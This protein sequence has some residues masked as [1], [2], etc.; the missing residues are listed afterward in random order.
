M[1]NQ[2][3]IPTLVS[4][5]SSPTSMERKKQDIIAY[6]EILKKQINIDAE[7]RFAFFYQHGIG[8][9]N[10][11][12]KEIDPIRYDLIDEIERIQENYRNSD[13]SGGPAEICLYVSRDS[14]SSILS[15]AN[16]MVRHAFGVLFVFDLGKDDELVFHLCTRL[17]LPKP[18]PVEDN[19]PKTILNLVRFIFY[20]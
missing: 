5:S 3:E 15:A 9:D 2:P 19:F 7:A 16:Q 20:N 6:H 17:S 8:A 18:W 10:E 1:S 11:R 12:V 14:L 13:T 4:P